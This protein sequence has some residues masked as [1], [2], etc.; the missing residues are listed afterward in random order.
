MTVLS[1]HFSSHLKEL[2]RRVLISFLAI[3]VSS[4]TI[5][6]FSE[7]I[8]RF[9]MVPLFD[10]YPDLAR[11]VYTNLTE[12]FVSYLKVSLLV[13]VII[14]FPVLLYQFW[15][16]VA[17]G[18]LKGERKLAL[19]IVSWGTGLFVAGVAFAYFVVMPKALT[20]LLSFAGK[21]LV[22]LPKLDAYLTFVVRS[23]LAFGL[24]FEIPFLMV[25][26]AKAG[27]VDKEYFIKQR[28]YFYIAILVLSFLLTVGDVLSTLLLSFPLFGLYEAGILAV[29]LFRSPEKDDQAVIPHGSD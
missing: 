12:A 1:G 18:L 15:R 10:A 21:D 17:P 3:L 2:R 20:F 7:R 29:R 8:A 19:M 11:L 6:I 27:L 14:S 22:P 4:G 5:Y 23:S 25:G 13:G 24:A 26:A 28:K 9:F 16:F